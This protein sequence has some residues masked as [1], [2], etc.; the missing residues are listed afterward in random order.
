MSVKSLSDLNQSRKLDK[1]VS[2]NTIT[3]SIILPVDQL[4]ELSCS[5]VLPSY[6]IALIQNLNKIFLTKTKLNIP[7]NKNFDS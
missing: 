5:D 3:A 4:K 2:S 6:S 7:N 1:S